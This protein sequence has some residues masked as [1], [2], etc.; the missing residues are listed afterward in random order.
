M[1]NSAIFNFILFTLFLLSIFFAETSCSLYLFAVWSIF[2]F[3][4]HSILARNDREKSLSEKKSGVL[5]LAVLFI[6]L[7]VISV[8][9]SSNLPLSL[10]KLFFYS[11]T[12]ATFIFF[13]LHGNK[14]FNQ[15][16]FVNYLLILTSVLNLLV[17]LLSIFNGSNDIFPGT[18]LLVRNYGHNH[19]VAF[20]LMVIPLIWYLFL[21]NEKKKIFIVGLL[22]S[23]YLLIVLS[24]GRVALLISV[25]QFAVIFFL[26]KKDFLNT[27]KNK[28]FTNILIKVVIFSFFVLA[29]IV[30]T[31]LYKSGSNEAANSCFISIFNKNFCQATFEN[32]RWFYW[33]KAIEICSQYPFF[34]YGL[35]TFFHASRLVPIANYTA[36]IFAHNAFLQLFAEAGIF[37]GASFLV[38]IIE[39][40]RRAI[41]LVRRTKN[42]FLLALL[43]ACLSS[44]INALFDYDWSLYIILVLTFIFLAIILLNDDSKT[45]MKQSYFLAGKFLSLNFMATIIFLV[46]SIFSAVLIKFNQDDLA[47]KYLPFIRIKTSSTAQLINLNQSSIDRLIK[48]QSANPDFLYILYL[49]SNMLQQDKTKILLLISEKDP[50]L[51]MRIVNLDEVSPGDAEL[52]TARI[53]EIEEKYRLL[54]NFY[55]VDYWQQHKLAKQIYDLAQDNFQKENYRQAAK[56]YQIALLLDQYV[57]SDSDALFLLEKDRQKLAQF[58]LEFKAFDPQNIHPDFDQY[59]YQYLEALLYLFENKQMEEFYVLAESIFAHEY[60]F[61]WFLFKKLMETSQNEVDKTKLQQVHQHF[62][63]YSTW[64]GYSLN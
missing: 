64:D 32:P 52:L 33:Q 49:N 14:I 59:M 27:F 6:V 1:R 16:E 36:S 25:I 50:L 3:I 44:V 46:F 56:Y 31:A 34:G 4:S 55:F 58:F 17:L 24:L 54:N 8:I 10:E 40:Y 35:N 47:I 62:A 28:N 26:N 51:F 11:N 2:L 39:L 45:N 12:I 41:L 57:L 22:L 18:N 9:F 15:K 21:K 48:M 37:V 20:L 23:S 53:V 43:I 30:L 5:Y 63:E 19:Y 29:I 7:L 61:S 42:T 38:F 60:N 13:L